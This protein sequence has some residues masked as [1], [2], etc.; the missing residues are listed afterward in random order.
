MIGIEDYR[1]ALKSDKCKITFECQCGHS[2]EF[3]D[4]SEVDQNHSFDILTQELSQANISKAL[5]Q[6]D[7]TVQCLECK[8]AS[9]EIFLHHRPFPEITFLFNSVSADE[10][11]PYFG[12]DTTIHTRRSEFFELIE[13]S[14]FQVE[15]NCACG[16]HSEYE[17]W[18]EFSTRLND[19]E[20]YKTTL[21]VESPAFQLASGD[22]EICCP[23][24]ESSH[25]T[26]KVWKTREG[27]RYLLS[28]DGGDH[29]PSCDHPIVEA[30]YKT[31]PDA[32]MIGWEYYECPDCS[33]KL[34]PRN[35]E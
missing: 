34:N 4:F 16:Y 1:R 25:D 28:S 3:R 2:V 26:D 23:D 5:S 22:F 33:E 11:V 14:D 9:Y 7:F 15:F 32:P 10:G 13:E 29:C 6:E 20:G 18:D 12:P 31:G 30:G 19:A 21:K 24:C 35:L 8:S 17:S 27:V